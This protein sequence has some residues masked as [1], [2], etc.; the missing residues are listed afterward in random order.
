MSDGFLLYG[1]REMDGSY[2]TDLDE[3]GGH[4]GATQHSNGEEFYHYHIINEF[5][6]GSVI[7]LFGVDLQGTPNRIL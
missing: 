6:F 4:Y 7:V 5:Y 1:R 3:S 2:P